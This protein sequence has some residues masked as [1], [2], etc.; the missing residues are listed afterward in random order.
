VAALQLGIVYGLRETLAGRYQE[1]FLIC[2]SRIL[3]Q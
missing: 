2:G 3:E 1:S